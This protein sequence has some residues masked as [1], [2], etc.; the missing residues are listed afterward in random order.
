MSSRT[1]DEIIYENLHAAIFE[2]QLP[3]G[4]RLPEDELAETFGVSRTGIRKVLQRLAHERLVDIIP[5]RG[6]SVA[7][8]SVKEAREVFAARRMIECAALPQVIGHARPAQIKALGAIMLKEDEAQLAGNR[9]AAIRYSGEFHL[10]L[11]RIADNDTLAH[12]LGELVARSSL[13]IAT[14]GAPIAVSC[15]HSEHE[16]ILDLISNRATAEAVAWMDQHLL[17]VE[18]SCSFA[19]EEAEPDL[20]TILGS[21]AQRGTGLA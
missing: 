16:Q 10:A 19:Q 9:A 7:Q 3:P 2:V 17:S 12:F 21:I 5:N 1:R 13:I 20:K 8:P 11:I 6:A 18:R 4:T 15:R 14:Y